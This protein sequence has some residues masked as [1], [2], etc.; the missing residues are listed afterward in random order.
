MRPLLQAPD[1]QRR[2]TALFVASRFTAVTANRGS[3]THRV[4][5]ALGGRLGAGAA[6]GDDRD[7]RHFEHVAVID[8]R[9]MLAEEL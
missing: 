5:S 9:D 3:V 7:G 8:G 6:G 4:G 1:V 2:T